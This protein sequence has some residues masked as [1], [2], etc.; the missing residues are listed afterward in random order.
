MR[1][2]VHRGEEGGAR[3]SRVL[4]ALLGLATIGIDLLVLGAP[5]EMPIYP[6]PLGELV[7]Q[8]ASYM[9]QSLAVEG[10][11]VEGSLVQTD[12]SCE[13]R[14]TIE[15]RGAQLPIHFAKCVDPDTL[16]DVG[17]GLVA[18]GELRADHSLEASEAFSRCPTKY[19]EPEARGWPVHC[20]P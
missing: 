15:D 7:A 9:G 10:R 5:R 13:V 1:V 2:R 6:T 17:S 3:R 20:R 11:L 18:R 14:F 4:L 16:R 12:S 8:P 19:S